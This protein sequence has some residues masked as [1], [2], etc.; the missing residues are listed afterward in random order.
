[1]QRHVHGMRNQTRIVNVCRRRYKG[2]FSGANVRCVDFG[3]FSTESEIESCFDVLETTGC[4]SS[5]S[6]V[7]IDDVGS[8]I[9]WAIKIPVKCVF[10]MPGTIL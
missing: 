6:L 5:G 8:E 9:S 4:T 10:Q 3:S 2:V 7:E 1:M